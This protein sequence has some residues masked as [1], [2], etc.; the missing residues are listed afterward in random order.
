M[1]GRPTREELEKAL[2]KA[3]EKLNLATEASKGGL[4]DWNIKT[5]ELEFND[6]WARM[7][8]YAPE[9]LA[10]DGMAAW[11]R[12]AHPEDNIKSE[13]EIQKHLS[14]QQPVYECE[15]RIKH[16]SGDYI[17]ILDRGK[18]VE[19]DAHGNPIRM[20]GALIDITRR[21][22]MEEEAQK[23]LSLLKAAIQSTAD[24]I[25]VTDGK[26]TIVC[27]N[28]KF[29]EMWNLPQKIL[30]QKNDDLALNHVLP[31]LEDPSGF[32]KKVR[33]LYANPEQ[34]SLDVFYFKDGRCFERYSQ[35]QWI[36]ESVKGRVWSFR[37][38]TDRKNA[39]AALRQSE[40]RFRTLVEQ[41]PLGI[42]LITKNGDYQYV[43]PRFTEMFGY[44]LKDVPTGRQWFE[45]AYP[46]EAERRSVLDAWRS[47]RKQTRKGRCRPGV[48]TVTCKDGSR[49]KIHFRPVFMENRGQLVIYEDITERLELENQ[50]Q[51]AQKFEAIG[52]LAGGIAHDFN[53]LLMGIQGWASLLAME[54]DPLSPLRKHSEAIEEYVRIAAD[55][56]R[57]L[58][59]FAR[60]GK[61]QVKPIDLNQLVSGAAAMF[62]RTCKAIQIHAKIQPGPLAIEADKQQIEQVVL[63]I[64]V[65]A[66]Q[67]M[68]EGGEIFLETKSVRLDETVC[69]PHRVKPGLFAKISVTDTGIGMDAATCQRIFDPFFTT[70]DKSRGTGLG[71]P[72]AYGIVKNHGGMITVYSVPGHGAT[73]T[74][75]FPVSDQQVSKEKIPEKA[76]VKGSETILLVDDEEMILKVGRRML[77][78]LGY[79]V[80][81]AK[82]GQQAV[83]AVLEMK[84]KIR[85]VI[86]D[87]IM[88]GMDGGKVFDKIRAIQTDMPVI[89]S[90]GFSL[91]GQANKVMQK[92]CNGFIK[93]LSTFP[94]FPNGSEKRCFSPPL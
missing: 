52:T 26:G 33:A 29:H 7:L 84:D 25:L 17:W 76:P 71:L 41:S 32:M 82:G 21:K 8:G 38:V 51:Q 89:L 48:F 69:D 92:G 49:K 24:G 86:L 56:T 59:G 34:S 27:Y 62:G 30:G 78:K 75:F 20:A 10:F 35:P 88:P 87:L 45:K 53:N 43:N 9:E 55:L 18:V 36:G 42:S 72:S 66:S 63:N 40:E 13:E 91:E 39:E 70:K 1:S 77:E 64:L 83:K 46:D 6:R 5:G 81:V 85:L 31:Q 73:F 19:K 14:G 74:I 54:L 3:E 47:A 65:N 67:A 93:N 79:N 11:N 12:L 57:Q 80:I 44:T 58:L 94:S 22:K 37:D 2:R 15:V 28:D 61:Y 90:S 60:R 4:W 50:L 23:N 16:K 68:P